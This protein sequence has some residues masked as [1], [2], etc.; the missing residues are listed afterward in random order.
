[1]L[2]YRIKSDD[3]GLKNRKEGYDWELHQE[4]CGTH[5]I[6]K[7]SNKT[8]LYDDVIS[9]LNKLE[10][11]GVCCTIGDFTDKNDLK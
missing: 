7:H 11:P 2:F 8:R 6:M 1:M 5:N 4:V 10:T 3:S 9:V